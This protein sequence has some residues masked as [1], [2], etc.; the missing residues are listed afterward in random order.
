MSTPRSSGSDIQ[1][2]LFTAEDRNPAGFFHY[3]GAITP[4]EE[5]ALVA[6]FAALPFAPF[7]F[8]GH[9]G[10]RRVIS[11]G[12][13]YDYAGQQIRPSA[14]IPGF[15]LPLRRRAAVLA[16]LPE[17]S[18]QQVLVTEYRPGAGIGWHRDKPMFDRVVAFSLLSSC[19][20]RF[21]RREGAA[22]ARQTVVIRPQAAYVLR[23]PARREWEH[24]IPPVE[25]LRYSVTFRDFASDKKP[26]KLA[27]W[28]RPPT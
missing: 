25:S 14:D 11:F 17:A 18:L 8:H 13:R 19:Q 6:E 12:W 2:A 23:G 28:G 16:G 1:G 27:T 26:A 3:P 21:R 9:V 24:S 20:L 15:L 7:E 4:D 22:W 5:Q 10:K